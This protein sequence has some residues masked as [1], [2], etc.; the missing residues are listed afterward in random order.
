MVYTDLDTKD[1]A[2]PGAD[3]IVRAGLPDWRPGAVI[4]LHDGG[5]DR[6]QTVAAL[7]QLIPELKR[8]GYTFDTVT[9]AV[10]LS[11]PWHAAT[12]VQTTGRDRW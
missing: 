12:D 3:S 6:G 1:W 2:R 8:R 11:P 5:G 10:G 4:M 7:D 9:S